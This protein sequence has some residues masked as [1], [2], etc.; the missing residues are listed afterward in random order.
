MSTQSVSGAP[1]PQSSRKNPKAKDP[2]N[3]TF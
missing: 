1:A 2:S 3:D